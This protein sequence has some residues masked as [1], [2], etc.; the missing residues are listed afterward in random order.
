MPK[1]AAPKKDEE[2]K[3]VKRAGTMEQTAADAQEFLDRAEKKAS[4]KSGKRKAPEAK[5]PKKSPAKAKSPAKTAA[6]PKKSPAKRA[7]RAGT[8]DQTAAEGANF[9]A[10]GEK[11]DDSDDKGLKRAGMSRTLHLA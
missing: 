5:S 9:L 7:K 10:K 1:R 6:S 4:P 3:E 11:K 8:M 2:K